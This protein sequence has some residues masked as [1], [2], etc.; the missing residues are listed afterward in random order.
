MIE[1][2]IKIKIKNLTKDSL[3]KVIFI[4]LVNCI[5]IV[6]NPIFSVHSWLSFLSD[7]N[8]MEAI[9]VVIEITTMK[10]F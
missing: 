7:L 8:K 2:F 6:E 1:F 10:Y 5:K 9:R 4:N 3:S